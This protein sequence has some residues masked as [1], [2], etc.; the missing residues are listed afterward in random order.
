[1]LVPIK[2]GATVTAYNRRAKILHR[3]TVLTRKDNYYL[4]Q[5]E[6]KDLGC[7]YCSDI[8]VASHGIPEILK[9]ACDIA[10]GMP[11]SKTQTNT[12]GRYGSLPYG[13]SYG[14]LVGKKE[15]LFVITGLFN[16]TFLSHLSML[17]TN[18]QHLKR[19]S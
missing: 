13:T 7:E 2:V 5:F 1:V 10:I 4:V 12:P 14:S 17:A 15:S 9:P 18:Q 6:R 3:G 8:D 19:F 16:F 11:T